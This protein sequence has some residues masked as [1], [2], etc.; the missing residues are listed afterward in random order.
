MKIGPWIFLSSIVFVVGFLVWRG[1]IPPASIAALGVAVFAWLARSPLAPTIE[2][3]L[4]A[5]LHKQV[6]AF[7]NST[8][9]TAQPTTNPETP[10]AKNLTPGVTPEVKP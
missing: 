9:I 2:N 8:P 4:I 3:D 10:T 5:L 1:I 6:D 7:T